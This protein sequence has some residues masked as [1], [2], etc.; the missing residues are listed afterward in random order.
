[1]GIPTFAGIPCSAPNAS[2]KQTKNRG[3]T[4]VRAMCSGAPPENA[5]NTYISLARSESG[6][7]RSEACRCAS[8]GP[9]S[10]EPNARGRQASAYAKR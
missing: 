8:A 1:M 5:G 6:E 4:R 2:Q 9:F 10:R 3:K 7:C